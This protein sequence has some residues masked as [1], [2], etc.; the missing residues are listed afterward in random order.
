MLQNGHAKLLTALEKHCWPT[1]AAADLAGRAHVVPYEKHSTIFHSGEAADL[2]Y[3][4]LSGEAK[5]EYRATDGS[6][7]LV[8]IA[9]AGQMLGL[10]APEDAGSASKPRPEQLFTARALSRCKVAIIPTERVA[11]GLQELSADELVRVLE[12]SRE[13]WVRLSCRLLEYLSMGIRFR[14]THALSEIADHF[15]VTDLRGRLIRLRL[16][17]EDLAALVGASRPMVSKHLKELEGDGVLARENGRYRMLAP[18]AATNGRAG[19]RVRATDRA[20]AGTSETGQWRRDSG[21]VR[22]DRQTGG[23]SKLDQL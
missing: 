20:A 6:E 11:R 21:L 5:L 8:S 17:H 16:S 22:R 7:L 19:A 10:F 12:N 9:D 1:K 14:L 13:H 3:V 2:V 15:G 18:G 23:A 4:L